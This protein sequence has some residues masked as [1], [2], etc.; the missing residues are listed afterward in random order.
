M[1]LQNI[2]SDAETRACFIPEE[3][4]IML[5]ADYSSQ[6]Q[7]VLANFAKEANLINFYQKG[8]SDMHSYNAFLMYPHI[9]RCTIDELTPDKLKY[10]KDEYSDLRYLA[11]TAGFAII[12]S[13]FSL[14]VLLIYVLKENLNLKNFINICIKINLNV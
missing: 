14:K 12:P 1:N 11:K 4:N 9:R 5:D 7:I 2:P 10:I 6:E 8:F 3:D 13:K